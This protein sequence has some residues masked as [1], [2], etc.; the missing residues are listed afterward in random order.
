MWFL[1]SILDI[2]PLAERER[3]REKEKESWLLYFNCVV[4]CLCSVTLPRLACGL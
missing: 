3:E 4:L 1:V 2:N